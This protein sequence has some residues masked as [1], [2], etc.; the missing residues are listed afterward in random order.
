ML[1]F[2]GI[3]TRLITKPINYFTEEKNVV[4]PVEN[5][6]CPLDVIQTKRKVFLLVPTLTSKQNQIFI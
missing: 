2:I 5:T 3:V 1:V 6:I 4:K